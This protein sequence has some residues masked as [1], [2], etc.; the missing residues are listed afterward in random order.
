MPCASGRAPSSDFAVAAWRCLASR[1]APEGCAVTPGVGGTAIP[2]G[3]TARLSGT[4][5]WPAG[6][7]GGAGGA[8]GAGGGAAALGK[9][10]SAGG[11]GSC[12]LVESG[13]GLDG[14]GALGGACSACA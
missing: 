9:V 10:G 5:D 1:R 3:V 8:G 11:A 14:G 13:G 2:T 12:R 6:G 4:A 7:G